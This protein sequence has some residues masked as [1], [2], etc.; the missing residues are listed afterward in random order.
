MNIEF[1]GLE[2]VLATLDSIDDTAKAEK[3]LV[4]ACALVERAAKQKAPKG[5]GDLRRSITSR[6]E[7]LV[8]EVYTPLEY[9][10]YVEYGTG[11][12]AEDGKGRQNVPWVYVEGSTKKP[13]SSKSYTLEEAQE[14]VQYL[15][16]KGLEAYYTY[17]REPQPYMRPALYENE[18]EILRIIK[19]GLLND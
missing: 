5:D 14:T 9:A 2:D 19:E 3:A 12:Y 15:R 6:V 10:P 8:G 11:I 4:K 13:T 1:K 17:G 18:E 16:E 7:N